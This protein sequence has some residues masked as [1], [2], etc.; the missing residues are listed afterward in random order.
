[1]SYFLWGCRGILTLITLRSERVD[2]HPDLGEWSV[3]VAF[4]VSVVGLQLSRPARVGV[5]H[6]P[7][8][9][10]EQR[11][12]RAVFA[13]QHVHLLHAGLLQELKI[14]LAHNKTLLTSNIHRDV[15]HKINLHELKIFL[16]HNKTLLTSNIHRDVQHKIKSPRTQNIPSTQ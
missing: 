4:P 1:M 11:A 14:F 3:D 5:H 15:Q 10:G 6:Q 2:W 13:G 12:D 7:L 8:H 9:L 16:A